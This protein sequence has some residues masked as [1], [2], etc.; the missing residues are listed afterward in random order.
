LKTKMVESEWGSLKSEQ[1]LN[2]EQIEERARELL[3]QMTLQEKLEQMSGDAPLLRGSLDMMREYNPEPIPAGENLR[4]NIPGI[5]FSDGPRGVVMNHSTCFPVSMGRGASWDVGLEERVGDAIGVEARTL[6]ANF[7]GGVCINLL[8]HPAWG[9]AQE[10]YGE[11]PHL[12][13]EMGAALV[14]GVQRHIMACA[15]HYACNSIENARFKVDVRV[16]ERTLR[17][18]YL[19]HF[20]RCVDE[21]VAGVMSAYNKVN[22]SYCGHN[23]HLLNGIL[24]NDWGF[25]GIVMSDFVWGVRNAKAAA[26]AGLDLEM[27]FRNH[28]YRN[29]KKLVKKGQVPETVI[30]GAVMRILRQKLRFSQVGERGRY[31]KEV[32]GGREHRALAR[33]AAVKSIVLLK[34]ELAR[35]GA[36]LLPLDCSRTRRIGVIGKLATAANIGDHGSSRVRPSKVITLLEAMAAGGGKDYEIHYNNG[37]NPDQAAKLVRL[38]DVVV[39]IAG[40]NHDDEGEFVQFK[41][42]GGDRA[43]LQLHPDDENLIQA[44]S[45]VNPNIIVVLIGGSAIITEAWREQVPAI[46]MAWYPGMEGGH[47]IADILYGKASPSARLPCIF[48]KSETQLPFF[49]RDATIIEYGDYHGYRLLDKNDQ[50][51][52]FAFGYGLTYTKFAYCDLQ[53]ENRDLA[54]DGVVRA[55]IEVGNVGGLAGDEIVQLYTGYE[56]SS[57]E[58]SKK[59]LKGFTKIHLEAGEVRRVEIAVPA[60]KLAY[61]DEKQSEWMVEPIH[62]RLY[63]GSSSRKEDLLMDEFTI[64]S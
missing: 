31:R 5:R 9:R 22:G 40:Y 11:D 10:T 42:E 51:A 62:Y 16:K 50:E 12:L 46:L 3:K 60:A 39:V 4:L 34:N 45:V 59:D 58:R 1:P 47:A 54:K 63:M 52:A 20:K 48:P 29:L 8:R 23:E 37:E 38:V 27:P 56:G 35:I 36:P 61:F 41:R 44:L 32:V 28:Y 15:K 57:V 25:D 49:D 6:G 17:E 21:G 43:S 53:I 55:S 19:P 30:D 24:K 14:R 7:F 13:G 2:K 33:E 26:M 64:H 18:I